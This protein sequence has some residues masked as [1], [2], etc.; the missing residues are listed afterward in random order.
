MIYSTPILIGTI[1]ELD[2]AVVSA[3]KYGNSVCSCFG[4]TSYSSRGA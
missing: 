4:K 1:D 2:I 3:N